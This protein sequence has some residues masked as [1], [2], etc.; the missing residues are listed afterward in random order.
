MDWRANQTD[1]V[2]VFSA[3]VFLVHHLGVHWAFYLIHGVLAAIYA[4]SLFAIAKRTIPQLSSFA[5]SLVVFAIFTCLHTV[6]IAEG[7]SRILPGLRQFF[8]WIES[9]AFH[10]THGMAGQSILG[11]YLEPS[12][13]GVL[14][15]FSIALFLRGREYPA[16]ASAACA[17]IMHATYLFHTALLSGAFLLI[18]ALER[19]KRQATVT[20]ILALVLMLPTLCHVLNCFSPTDSATLAKAQTILV[21]YRIPH[22]AIISEWFSPGEFMQLILILLGLIFAGRNRR[23]FLVLSLCVIGSAGLT[24]IQML[25]GSKSLALAFPWRTSTWLVPISTVIVIGRFSASVA[26]I[27]SRMRPGRTYRVFQQG[28]IALSIAFLVGASFLGVRRTLSS[29]RSN[30]RADSL[31]SHIIT[32]SGPDQV[33]L[34]PLNFDWFRLR[35]GLPIFIDWK[36]HP[37]RDFELLEWYE[38]TELAR[39]FYES[40]DAGTARG[41]FARILDRSPVTHIVAATGAQNVPRIEGLLLEYKDEEYLV[42]RVDKSQGS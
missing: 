24:L 2:P 11:P 25:S 19:K 9:V 27:I 15:L 30:L 5:I 38:R 31:V 13:F 18:L 23:L 28:V 35:T 34:V 33:Y 10:A 22:H 29:S 20:A 4:W 42:F 14:L 7:L 40:R 12:A 39:A 3:L 32:H 1:P 16:V 26:T 36:C 17:A 41:A 6:W 37:Y 8:P 21:E